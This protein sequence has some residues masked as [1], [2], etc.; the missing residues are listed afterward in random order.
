MPHCKV[1]TS[2]VEFKITTILWTNPDEATSVWGSYMEFP[3]SKMVTIKFILEMKLIVINSFLS[4]SKAYLP[5]WL[6]LRNKRDVP[7]LRKTPLV[8]LIEK[9][10]YMYFLLLRWIESSGYFN[11]L[12]VERVASELLQVKGKFKLL[13]S[14]DCFLNFSSEIY[15]FLVCT[16]GQN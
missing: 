13:V 12:R 10:E 16:T 7:V 4:G 1:R 3:A 9:A 14:P 15:F 5:A 8:I 2:R 11:I 6:P